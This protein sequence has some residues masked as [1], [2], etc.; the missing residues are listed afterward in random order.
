[1]NQDG[2]LTLQEIDDFLDKNF[3]QWDQNSDGGLDASELNAAFSQFAMP[4]MP[5][6]AEP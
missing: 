1:M 4:D 3:A 6:A 2:F 5:P